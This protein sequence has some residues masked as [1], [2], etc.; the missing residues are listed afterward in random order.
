MDYA[1]AFA[2]AL[3]VLKDEGRYRVFADIRR[4]RGLFPSARHFAGDAHRR[5]EFVS[6]FRGE[7]LHRPLGQ[8]VRL[9][10]IIIAVGDDVDDGV[11]HGNDVDGLLAHRAA[12]V[13]VT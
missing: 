7:Q 1:K 12:R 13:A 10:E 5:I 2:N 8:F 4:N 6:L 3:Q 11:P 9:D